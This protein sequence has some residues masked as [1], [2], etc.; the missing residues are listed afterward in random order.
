MNSLRVIRWMQIDK[1][2]YDKCPDLGIRIQEFYSILLKVLPRNSCATLITLGFRTSQKKSVS[3]KKSYRISQDINAG[4]QKIKYLAD[5]K[6]S[7]KLTRCYKNHVSIARL[8]MSILDSCGCPIK[9]VI[10]QGNYSLDK[11]TFLQQASPPAKLLPIW[12][13]GSNCHVEATALPKH[14]HYLISRQMQACFR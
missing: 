10:T 12:A 9:Q 8:S 4:T 7:V 2:D 5:F 3:M 13:L 1:V 11:Y 14:T 6:Q